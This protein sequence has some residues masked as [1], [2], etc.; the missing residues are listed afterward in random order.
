MLWPL[1][2]EQLAQQAM[3]EL[4][5]ALKGSA[6]C[7]TLHAAV[8]GSLHGQ[9]PALPVLLVS[10]IHDLQQDICATQWSARLQAAQYVV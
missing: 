8:L 10:H 6:D 7:F 4:D 9:S 2:H 3:Q 1:T 5:P